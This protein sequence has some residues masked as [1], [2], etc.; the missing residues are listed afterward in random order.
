MF[1]G[2]EPFLE[3]FPTLFENEEIMG[4]YLFTKYT[5]RSMK[6]I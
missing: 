2:A 5:L 1:A 3:G 6:A 4:L